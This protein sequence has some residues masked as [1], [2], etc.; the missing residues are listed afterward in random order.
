MEP[1]RRDEI[2]NER[3][4]KK[5]TLKQVGIVQALLTFSSRFPLL[6]GLESKVLR[7]DWVI[8]RS[9]VIRIPHQESGYLP[10][11]TL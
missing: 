7:S 10:L 3:K 2:S 1:S 11:L 5:E 6:S 9:R 8:A 4:T